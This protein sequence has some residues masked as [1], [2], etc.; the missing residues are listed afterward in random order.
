MM[1]VYRK[2]P[3]DVVQKDEKPQPKIIWWGQQE[4]N[5]TTYRIVAKDAALTLEA[6]D[7]VDAMGVKRWYPL[8]GTELVCSGYDMDSIQAKAKQ[9]ETILSLL[10]IAIA[11]R[12]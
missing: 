2:P 11:Q 5:D 8:R 12:V 10:V 3:E 6:S 4:G 9:L 1:T 7:S